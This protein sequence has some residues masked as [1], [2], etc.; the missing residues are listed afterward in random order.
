MR[1]GGLVLITAILTTLALVPAA[2]GTNDRP[3]AGD[4]TEIA[5]AF[6]LDS[7]YTRD[8]AKA[9]GAK[10]VSVIIKLDEA[11]IASYEGGVPG[12]PATS[13]KVTGEK[14]LNPNSAHVKKYEK[15]LDQNNIKFAA[16]LEASIP[17]AEVT[18]SYEYVIGGVAAIVPSDELT[19]IAK[20]EGVSAI[21]LDELNQLDTEASPA[22]I[23]ADDLWDDLGGQSVAGES[24][25]VANIDTGIW[26]EH[27]SVADPGPLGGVYPAPPAHWNGTGTGAGCDFGNVA[28]NASD[29]PFTCNNKLLGAYNFTTTYTAVIG[30]LPTEYDS[31]RDSNGHGT[32]T[33]T[34]AAGNGGV[35]APIFG[36]DRGPVSGIAPRAR[37]V[38]YKGCGTQG[39]FSSDTSAAIQQ[40]VA[41]GV[42]V[43]NYSIS[44]GSSPYS[45]VVSLAML[46]AYNAGTLVVPSAGN[47]GPGADTVAH[48]EPWTLTVGASTTD[49]HFISTIDLTAANSDTL[50]LTG[51][52]L[53][54]GITTDT[55]VIFAPGGASDLCLTPFAPGTFSG[56]IVICKRGLIARVAKSFNVAAGGAGGLLLYNP[57]QQGLAT[58]NHFIPSV[59]LEADQGANL[60]SFMD[61]HVSVTG[62]FTQGE[63]TTVQGD[64]MAA[65]SSRGGPG[66]TLGISKPDVTAPGVQILAG[67]TPL[68]EDQNGGLPGQLFQ[69]IQGTSMSAPHATGATALVKAAHPDWTPGE[70]KSALMMSAL[71]LGVTKE[72]G[73]TPADPFDYGSGRILPA[74]AAQV[75]LTI[76][77]TGA[78]FLALQD[79]LWDANYPSLYVPV[80]AGAI[81]V[82][83]TATNMTNRIGHWNLT[84]QS[85][86]DLDVWVTESLHVPPNGGVMTFEITVDGRDLPIGVVRHAMVTF[87]KTN[88]PMQ[89]QQLHFPITVVRQQTGVT[90]DK[91]CS[92]SP[93]AVGETT[94]CTI[95]IENTTFDDA[96]VSVSDPIP[97]GLDLDKHS[98]V[99]AKASRNK[100]KFSGTLAGASPPSPDVAVD[101]LA[102]PFGYF[103]LSTFGSSF[104]I[105]ATDESI[106]NFTVPS[107]D[108]AGESYTQIGIVSNGYLVVGGGTG[109]DVEFINTDLP[110]P[111]APNNTVAPFW[112]DLNP[113]FGGRVLINVL[114]SGGDVWT[115]VEW[116]SVRSFGDVETTTTQVWLGS[117][118]DANPGE[119]ISF[120]Y[121][122][123]VSDGD[124]GFLTV[125]VENAF[126]NEG[127]TVYFDGVGTPPSPSFPF[128]V[129]GYEVDVFS[130]PGAPG[131][132]HVISYS[133]EGDSVGE[134]RNYAEM[135]SDIFSGVATA[136]FQVV[137]ID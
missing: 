41:D 116:E 130:I 65:F 42:D 113:A 105:G 37:V 20:M 61:S 125:G 55:P 63:P 59:H 90:I 21:Y 69:S 75:G 103:P 124:G 14:K 19:R 115:V 82:Q 29:A 89:G 26:P 38:A 6:S 28:F 32:H 70:I 18:Q 127:G 51:A 93:I 137:V 11:P 135:T 91:T 23:G 123:D 35:A 126:G 81:T 1:R 122:A 15:F 5:G 118:T 30:L 33:L 95:T 22:F 94:N 68:P 71:T 131:D 77:E 12:Y 92:P 40:A 102:S 79:R 34:T 107:F 99:G 110:N 56:E 45:D 111:A 136:R 44:G 108:Y 78:N 119:D 54:A 85:P 112:T 2:E 9:D 101:P 13:P 57:V 31:A 117:N 50:Q 72:D 64:K 121:G 60:V 73:S 128:A 16:A 74:D 129:P 58:D 3:E 134:W 48:R 87:E 104:D 100:V 27:P 83:R 109:A 84:A 52:S 8:A 39:C 47:S 62:T 114:A 17:D 49:R 7:V 80:F 133:A 43:V 132:T 53:T 88:E 98:V 96:K 120:V 46:D 4:L 106:A 67:N 66:Q 36:I 25:I 76:S 24:I 86:S 10:L 97:D